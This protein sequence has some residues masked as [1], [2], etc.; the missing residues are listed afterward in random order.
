MNYTTLHG[1]ADDPTMPPVIT[2]TGYSTKTHEQLEYEYLQSKMKPMPLAIVTPLPPAE[3]EAFD[4][5]GTFSTPSAA[6]LAILAGI[7]AVVLS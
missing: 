6:P 3:E 5:A 1:S 7:A 4:K 2:D